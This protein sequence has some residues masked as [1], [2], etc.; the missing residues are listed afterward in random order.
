MLGFSLLLISFGFYGAPWALTL[1]WAGGL[2]CTLSTAA[3]WVFEDLGILARDHVPRRLRHVS[4]L[5]NPMFWLFPL[6]VL[7][8]TQ[9]TLALIALTTLV[10][11]NF[12]VRMAISRG[13]P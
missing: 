13:R 7:Y 11:S 9:P 4:R 1:T 8:T 5:S 2:L 6:M 10:V 12:S 3:H